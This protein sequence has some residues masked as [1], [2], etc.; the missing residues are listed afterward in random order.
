MLTRVR[1]PVK[2]LAEVGE[3]LRVNDEDLPG[4]TVNGNVSPESPNM[5]PESI[6]CVTLR[7][8]VPGLLIVNVCVFVTPTVTLP[9][10]ELAGT[11][12]I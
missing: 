11:T 2:L 1:L 9:K 7:F 5:L 3:K 12:E 4:A 8:A 6:D 10:F